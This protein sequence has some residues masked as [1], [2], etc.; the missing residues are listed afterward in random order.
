MRRRKTTRQKKWRGRKPG[1]AGDTL[2]GIESVDTQSGG[3]A[4]RS[5]SGVDEEAGRWK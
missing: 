3:Q 5:I 4:R 2:I 1:A